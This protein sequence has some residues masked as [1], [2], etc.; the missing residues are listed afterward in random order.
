[1]NFTPY[2]Y[3]IWTQ[4]KTLYRIPCELCP[5]LLRR[6]LNIGSQVPKLP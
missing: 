6:K 2:H 5:M 1:M 3:Q 4:K